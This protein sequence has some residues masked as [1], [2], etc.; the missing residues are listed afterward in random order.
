MTSASAYTHRR[1]SLPPRAHGRARSRLR[2]LGLDRHFTPRPLSSVFSSINRDGHCAV[3]AYTSATR[4][5]SILWYNIENI[6]KPSS[7]TYHVLTF[8]L[9]V[10]FSPFNKL[11]L[12]LVIVEVIIRLLVIYIG[13]YI[14]I[15]KLLDLKYSYNRIYSYYLSMTHWSAAMNL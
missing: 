14:Y 13:L 12:Q 4:S 2:Q 1:F 10:F 7:R 11:L 3:C 5:L 15:C 8:F 9:C 6:Y